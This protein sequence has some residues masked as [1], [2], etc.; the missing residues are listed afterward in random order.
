MYFTTRKGKRGRNGTIVEGAPGVRGP[1]GARGH[2]G[3]NGVSIEGAPGLRGPQGVKGEPG[4]PGR[5]I[6]GLG[7][8][9][10][11]FHSNQ[12][13]QHRQTRIARPVVIVQQPTYIFQ[14]VR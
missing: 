10:V 7:L 4:Q 5:V 8:N 3:R 14:K 9:N 1:Q 6:A 11:E 2:A 13:I 12:F